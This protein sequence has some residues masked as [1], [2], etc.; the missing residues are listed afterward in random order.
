MYAE[1]APSIYAHLR[2]RIRHE[3]VGLNRS[4]HRWLTEGVEIARKEMEQYDEDGDGQVDGDLSKVETRGGLGLTSRALIRTEDERN[5]QAVESE[6]LP[7]A[8][9]EN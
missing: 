8:R 6:A 9:R 5:L 4:I 7:E 1:S 3:F 2:A